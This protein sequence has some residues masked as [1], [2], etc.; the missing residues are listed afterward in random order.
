MHKLTSPTLPPK[1]L[2]FAWSVHLFTATGALWGFLAII[3]TIQHQWQLAFFWLFAAGFVDSVDGAL[4]RKFQVSGYIPNF[5]GA[6]L[7]NIIDYLTYVIV[8]ALILYEAQL[9]PARWTILGIAALVLSS[10]YQFAQADAKTEDHYF[11]G[12]PSYWNVLAFYLFLLQWPAR[13]NLALVLLCAVLVFVPIKYVYPSRTPYYRKPT[14]ILSSIWGVV[15]AVLFITLNNPPQWLLY[16]SLYF[17]VYY[18][19]ISLYLMAKSP[20]S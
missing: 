11:K 18:V 19:G 5:D 13:I 12:F 6:L 8:P 17:V 2:W 4:A 9:L 20:T 14:L 1:E 7:D 10:A 15:T 3:A 16:G